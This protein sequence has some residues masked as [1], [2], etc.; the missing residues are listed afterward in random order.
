ME[1]GVGGSPRS[2]SNIGE[3][4]VKYRTIVA[5]P[6]WPINWPSSGTRRAGKTAAALTAP[7]MNKDYIRRPLPYETMS[8]EE[9]TALPVVELVA[10]D[11]NLFM[12]TLD[13]FVIDGSA[14][15]IVE[16]WG[17]APR[18]HMLVW[19]KRSAGL[20]R[21]FRP[22]HELM[23][24]GRRGDSALAEL[25]LPT[26]FDWKQ[27]Y[28]NGAKAHSAKPDGA[29]D[30]IEQLSPAPRLEMFARRNRLGWETWGNEALEHVELASGRSL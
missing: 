11:A 6:P 27:P 21:I 13:R 18:A 8:V 5:D 25:S 16:A 9:I 14:A 22:A 20:G 1:R 12:W 30:T 19:R 3:I 4:A 23:I 7:C 10:D 17:F 24:L 15:A 26:V 29:L 28:V 2:G